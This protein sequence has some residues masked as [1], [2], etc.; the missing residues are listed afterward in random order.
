MDCVCAVFNSVPILNAQKKHRQ[1]DEPLYIN[2]F[3]TDMVSQVFRRGRWSFCPSGMGRG[4][5]SRRKT[6]T[7]KL[8]L[9]GSRRADANCCRLR[10]RNRYLMRPQQ[11]LAGC[12]LTAVWSRRQVC[13]QTGRCRMAK[14]G[15]GRLLHVPEWCH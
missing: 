7:A 6:A 14:P 3:L 10:L 8:Q 11:S 2:R 1:F 13:C 15:R 9:C 5:R 12:A 4:R